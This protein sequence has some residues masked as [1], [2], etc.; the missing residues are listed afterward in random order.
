MKEY[1]LNKIEKYKKGFN[2]SPDIIIL[3]QSHLDKLEDKE[4]LNNLQIV[5]EDVKNPIIFKK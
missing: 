1:I 4:I 5:I 2:L 3:S